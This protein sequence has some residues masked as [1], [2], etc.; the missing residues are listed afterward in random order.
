MQNLE[1]SNTKF[2]P[3][4]TFILYF[5]NT[6]E[7]SGLEDQDSASSKLVCTSCAKVFSSIRGLQCHEGMVHSNASISL[8]CKICDKAFTGRSNLNTHVKNIHLTPTKFACQFCEKV[9]NAKLYLQRHKVAMHS[10]AEDTVVF[11]CQNCGKGFSSCSGLKRHAKNVHSEP[12]FKCQTCQK[13][14]YEK[15]HLN[16]HVKE[17][18]LKIEVNI[19]LCSSSG[20]SCQASLDDWS[21]R[22][23][24]ICCPND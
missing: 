18:H 14:F 5:S 11:V 19:T 1:S 9:F 20:N 2:Q 4:V 21:C 24:L 13:E 7:Q 6:G 15:P 10:N 17:V 23:A 3:S 12:G 8:R 22:D 16:R